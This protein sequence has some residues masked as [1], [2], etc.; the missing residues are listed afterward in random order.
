MIIKTTASG[1]AYGEGDFYPIL[2]DAPLLINLCSTALEGLDD[3]YFG[4][5]ARLAGASGFRTISIDLPCHGS[6]KLAGES[7]GLQGWSNCFVAGRDP[8]AEIL[9]ELK[10]IMNELEYHGLL[11]SRITVV[12]GTSRGGLLAL[13]TMVN[14]PRFNYAVA[15]APV[16]NLQY[17]KEFNSL[18]A[19]TLPDV[20]NLHSQSNILAR[21]KLYLNIGNSDDR[22]STSSAIDLASGIIKSAREQNLQPQIELHVNAVAGHTTMVDAHDQ[23]FAWLKNEMLKV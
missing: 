17:L 3:S 9:R 13:L 16:T 7:E 22:V 18:P 12:S 20:Y 19:A 4:R 8:I 11:K 1:I 6:K 5:I 15:F 23:A 10:F 21:R 14:D 2:P